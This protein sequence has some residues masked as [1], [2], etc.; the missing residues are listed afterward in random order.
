MFCVLLR[1]LWFFLNFQ[2]STASLPH[3]TS[4]SNPP[5]G[6]TCVAASS[7]MAKWAEDSSSPTSCRKTTLSSLTTRAK[8]Q[9]KKWHCTIMRQV[10]IS[11]AVSYRLLCFETWCLPLHFSL[12]P[13]S[14]FNSRSL[15]VWFTGCHFLYVSLR[16][17]HSFVSGWGELL[18]APSGSCPPR[19][20]QYLWRPG[21]YW[22]P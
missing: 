17:E 2:E 4:P 18:R 20:Q 11:S 16:P 3:G 10:T 1:R 12:P 21:G 15:L 8:V 6:L 13:H 7:Q 5:S 14:S 9:D 22:K 19:S